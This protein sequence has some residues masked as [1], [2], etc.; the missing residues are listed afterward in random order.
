MQMEPVNVIDMIRRC[1]LGGRL[2]SDQA[3]TAEP[4]SI[5]PELKANPEGDTTPCTAV[6]GR[7]GRVLVVRPQP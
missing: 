7:S 5:M 6:I 3:F 1:Q 2:Y 4:M